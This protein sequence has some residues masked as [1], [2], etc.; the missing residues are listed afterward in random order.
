[1]PTQLQ[2][3]PLSQLLWKINLFLGQNQDTHPPPPFVLYLHTPPHLFKSSP[4]FQYT[5]SLIPYHPHFFFHK[6]CLDAS[7]PNNFPIQIPILLSSRSSSQL[8]WVMSCHA[9]SAAFSPTTLSFSSG[10]QPLLPCYPFL[11]VPINLIFYKSCQSHNLS[12]NKLKLL[13]NNGNFGAAGV[14][15]RFACLQH[16]V[17]WRPY[18]FSELGFPVVRSC[19]KV[20]SFSP[21]CLTYLRLVRGSVL[22]ILYCKQKE[23]HHQFQP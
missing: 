12:E 4:L 3:P 15:E 8:A 14:A 17:L 11:L 19:I 6:H 5:R 2:A 9:S 7:I 1:M 18:G 10:S 21:Q 13:L 20:S 22:G 16:E 23:G